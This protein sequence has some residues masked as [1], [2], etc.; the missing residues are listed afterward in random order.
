MHP[1]AWKVTS[2]DQSSSPDLLTSA[3]GLLHC[4]TRPIL[5]LRD[6]Y[7]STGVGEVEGQWWQR[8]QREELHRQC[9]ST[10]MM[11]VSAPILLRWR[12]GM[13]PGGNGDP[14]LQLGKSE[15][16]GK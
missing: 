1:A 4:L 7:K 16:R 13:R 14:F 11:F 5:D 9:L 6:N 15:E 10:C 3:L 2:W 12:A 8:K